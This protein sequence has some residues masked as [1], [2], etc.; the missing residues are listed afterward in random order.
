MGQRL[1]ISECAKSGLF[2]DEIAQHLGLS[3]ADVASA[4]FTEAARLGR[5][6]A[7]RE[8]GESAFHTAREKGDRQALV[9]AKDLLRIADGDDGAEQ[10]PEITLDRDIVGDV[11]ERFAEF[12][13][14]SLP[15]VL[16]DAADL[17]QLQS[18]TGERLYE[19]RMQQMGI[20]K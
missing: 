5:L 1:E 15:H 18:L 8:L 4:D 9:Q 13:K 20:Q 19:S 3:D 12:Y 14:L 16:T 7:A 2:D 11:C 17:D 10:K 6:D